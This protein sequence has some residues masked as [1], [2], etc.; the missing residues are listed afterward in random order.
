ME[1][2]DQRFFH[3]IHIAPLPFYLYSKATILEQDILIFLSS[4]VII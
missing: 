4:L 3:I 2:L 1:L